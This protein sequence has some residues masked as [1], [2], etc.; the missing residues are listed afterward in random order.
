MLEGVV[1]A[2]N[3]GAVNDEISIDLKGGRKVSSIVTG[4]STEALGLRPGREFWPW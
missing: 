1:T 2:G 3:Q 4:R